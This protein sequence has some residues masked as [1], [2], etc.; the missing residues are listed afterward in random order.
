[1]DSLERHKARI[2]QELRTVGVTAYGLLKAESRQLHK[3]VKTDESIQGCVYGQYD[4]GSAMLV[5]TDKRLVF[6]DQKPLHS[7]VEESTYE[8]I[9]DIGVDWQPLYARVVVAARP[10]TY[11]LRYVN[12]HCAKIFIRYLESRVLG[13]NGKS[14]S[15]EGVQLTPRSA[16]AERSTVKPVAMTHG[17][18]QTTTPPVDLDADQLQFLLDH[19]R[20]VVSTCNNDA[21][22]YGAT[23]FYYP[24]PSYPQIIRLLTKSN[25]TTA[26][27]ISQNNKVALTITDDTALSTMNIAAVAN[28]EQDTAKA[29]KTIKATLE[30]DPILLP[31]VLPPVA[32]LKDGT[33]MV[34]ILTITSIKFA[35]YSGE[36]KGS[37][38]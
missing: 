31:G 17:V 16:D 8:K 10:R 38:Q 7:I 23:M 32:Q 11:T 36:S 13:V 4:G 28:Q 3:V 14:V 37:G 6:V 20:C 29:L 18:G 1:M 30:S 34:Y 26:N 22:P 12:T 5:A 15:K 33:Y 2:K 27:N 35:V 21:M 9:L 24:D 19:R 25:T